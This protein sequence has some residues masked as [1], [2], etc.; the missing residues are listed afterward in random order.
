MVDHV[1]LN[2]MSIEGALVLAASLTVACFRG[3][4]F[5]ASVQNFLVVGLESRLDVFS[6]A[7]RKFYCVPVEDFVERVG[8]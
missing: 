3:C 4:L 6:T 7:V 2:T 1:L 8:F 5:S